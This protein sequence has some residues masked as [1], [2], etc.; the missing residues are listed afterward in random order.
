MRA[1]ATPARGSAFHSYNHYHWQ[2]YVQTMV[3][4]E[5]REEFVAA[6]G[7]PADLRA[8][9]RRQARRWQ[10]NARTRESLRRGEAPLRDDTAR[11]AP[12]FASGRRFSRR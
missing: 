5:V 10:S 9:A 3:A 6:P 11:G 7:I 4:G 1:C 12:F 2:D 8:E